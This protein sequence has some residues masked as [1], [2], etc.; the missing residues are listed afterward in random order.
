MDPVF[1]EHHWSSLPNLDRL[2][3]QGDFKPLA[4]TIPPQSPVAWSTFI[5]GMDPDGHG[6]YD[7]VHRDPATYLPLSSMSKSPTPAPHL[8]NRP[9]RDP[10]LCRRRAQPTY[11]P[12]LLATALRTGRARPR[13]PHARQLPAR[14]LRSRVS[15]RHGYSRSDGHQ[16]HVLLLYR[17]PRRDP[18]GCPGRQDQPYRRRQWTAPLFAS[19]APPTASAKNRA[20]TGVDLIAHVDPDLPGVPL[21][22]RRPAVPPQEGEW[23]EWVRADFRLVPGLKSASGIFRVYLQKAHPHLAVYVSPVYMIP[24]RSP[25]CPSPH[26]RSTPANWPALSD[27]S[28][29]R[30]SP[31]TPPLIAPACYPRMSSSRKAGRCS[32]IACV[33]SSTP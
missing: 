9:L 33:C 12:R 2:R 25:R 30:E 11:R 17:Q 28:T 22:S 24:P 5:T 6:I 4:T 20:T 13:D 15:C 31:K 21:R 1:L 27:P 23:S 7:F 18:S 10:A 14:G 26:R 29:P 3:R 16:R 8:Q 32:P 19:K